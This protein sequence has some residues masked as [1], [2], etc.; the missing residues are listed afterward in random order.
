MMLTHIQDLVADKD[1]SRVIILLKLIQHFLK[2]SELG[3][4]PRRVV[5]K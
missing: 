2:R 1:T 5:L 4:I 3:L